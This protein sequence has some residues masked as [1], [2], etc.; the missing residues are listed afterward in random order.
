MKKIMII[1]LVAILFASCSN[2]IMP[3]DMTDNDV[4]GTWTYS[5][6][7]PVP[8]TWNIVFDDNGFYEAWYGN[9][10]DTPD[11]TGTWS[12]DSNI[13]TFNPAPWSQDWETGVNYT[14]GAS[15]VIDGFEFN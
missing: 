10:D 1:A 9:I 12:T 7:A 11:N 4:V 8:G 13:I 3:V 14:A 15:L 6:S 2:P 5:F